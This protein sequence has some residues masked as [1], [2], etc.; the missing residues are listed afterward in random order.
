MYRI[1]QDIAWR[2]DY[3]GAERSP[4]LVI[5]NLCAD[6][7]ALLTA[8]ETAHFIDIGPTYPGVRAPAPAGYGDWVLKV[9]ERQL[10]EVFGG[11]APWGFDLCAFSMVTTPPDA[12]S[13]LQSLPHFDGAEPTRLAF[14][15]YLCDEAH[16]GTSFYR[17]MST[18]FERLSPDRLGNYLDHLRVDSNGL[19]SQ[20]YTV[21]TSAIFE[22]IGGVEAQF[23][24][25]VF[26][27]GSLLHSGDILAPQRLSENVHTG[28][29]TING[30]VVLEPV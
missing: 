14:L 3:V 5:D 4:V 1:S 22:R 21:G 18:G 2:V 15:H 8:A 16:G 29:L 24:R 9:F 11:A 20:G 12:L 25:A 17:Q 27:P 30:F 7:A 28:R 26:Y 6:P 19:E 10:R 13:A 23:N